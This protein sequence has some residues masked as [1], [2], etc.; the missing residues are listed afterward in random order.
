VAHT[1]PADDVIADICNQSQ[2]FVSQVFH[3]GRNMWIT[4]ARMI[5]RSER[6][7]LGA[8]FMPHRL[9]K[10]AEVLG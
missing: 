7:A 2:R 10:M 4:G 1:F 3:A 6:I 8:P 9:V 5:L